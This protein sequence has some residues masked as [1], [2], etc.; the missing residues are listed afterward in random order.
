LNLFLKIS[1]VLQSP[2]LT[3]S[4]EHQITWLTQ[5]RPHVDECLCCKAE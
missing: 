2:I 1:T 3:D 4:K 5:Q